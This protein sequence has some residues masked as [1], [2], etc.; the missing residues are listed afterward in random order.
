MLAQRFI[1]FGSSSFVISYGHH[2]GF[3]HSWSIFIFYSFQLYRKL[4][5]T[6]LFFIELHVYFSLFP[7]L[8]WRLVVIR[9]QHFE[10]KYLDGRIGRSFRMKDFSTGIITISVNQYPLRERYHQIGFSFNVFF[11]Y[12]G[13]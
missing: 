10:K 6:L 9:W 12:D 3:W 13:T 4:P 1:F 5:F 2:I 8:F 11:S 7:I